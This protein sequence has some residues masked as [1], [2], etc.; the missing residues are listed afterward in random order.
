MRLW[1]GVL[2]ACVLSWRVDVRKRVGARVL[3]DNFSSG[4]FSVYCFVAGA[5]NLASDCVAVSVICA[6][7]SSPCSTRGLK[8]LQLLKLRE[9]SNLALKKIY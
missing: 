6:V 5:Q 9:C 4:T 1:R 8:S 2:L 3:K 7:L